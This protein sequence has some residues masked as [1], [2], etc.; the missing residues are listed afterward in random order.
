[1][2]STAIRAAF[3][4]PDEQ[5]LDLTFVT[6]RRYRYFG[7]PAA[8]AE[9]FAR[10]RSKGAWFNRH[11]RDRFDFAEIAGQGIDGEDFA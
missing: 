5:V 2:P 11:I 8:V 9:G 3:Y 10:A 7:V 1:M 6:G 4:R